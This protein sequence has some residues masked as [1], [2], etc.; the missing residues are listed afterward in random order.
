MGDK[1]NN[2]G[3]MSAQEAGKKGGEAPH[4]RRGR[5]GSDKSMQN[6]EE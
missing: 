1:N 5:Q 2:R 4:K 3:K 6:Q